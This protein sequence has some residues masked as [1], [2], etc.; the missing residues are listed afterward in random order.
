MTPVLE[1]EDL[2]VRYGRAAD[3]A[4]RDVS[5]QLGPG[6]ILGVVGESGS[7]K[8]TLGL[9]ALGLLPPSARAEGS[10]TF[11][12]RKLLELPPSQL[13]RL[14]GDAIATIM[15]NPSTALNPCYTIGNQLGEVF[16]IH[17]QASRKQA[18][19]QAVEWLSRVGIADPE[20]RLRAYPHEL[21]GGINQRIVIAMALALN[22]ALVVADEP[23]S[24]LD[25]TVQAGILRLLRT[26]IEESTSALLLITHDLGVVAQLSSRVIVMR[27]GGIVEQGEVGQIFAAPRHE[28]TRH[29]LASLPT[30]RMPGQA[31]QPA[32]SAGRDG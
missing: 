3:P 15:Q 5:L 14:R 2:T 7:G 13:R 30:R 23:T 19:R 11:E 26:L 6:E 12:G 29:L 24:A 4:V 25:V 9:A 17:R 32:E 28:Y 22:P 18:E 20:A 27:Q 16:R 8:T 1:V 31:G 10:V 21:S